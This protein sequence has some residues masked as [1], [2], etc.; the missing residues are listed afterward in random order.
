M[1]EEMTRPDFQAPHIDLDYCGCGVYRY[2]GL[3]ANVYQANG[4]VMMLDTPGIYLNLEIEC[5]K[6]GESFGSLEDIVHTDL[7]DRCEANAPL[8]LLIAAVGTDLYTLTLENTVQEVLGLLEP[9]AD[10]SEEGYSND[11]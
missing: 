9:P 1:K 11:E 6:G 7:P 10:Y 8:D 4:E 3:I 2:R 5:K